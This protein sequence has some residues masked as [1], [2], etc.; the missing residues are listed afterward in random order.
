MPKKQRTFLAT[1]RRYFLTGLTVF[2]PVL[3][4]VYALVLI[5]NIVDGFLAKFDAVR[6]KTR[7]MRK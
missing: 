5:F 6:K 3:L 7:A 2:L 4:T 1:I